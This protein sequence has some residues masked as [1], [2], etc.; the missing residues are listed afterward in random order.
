MSG[1][2]CVV[3][4]GAIGGLFAAH[5]AQLPELEVWVYDT[6]AE[7]VAAINSSGVRV[8]GARTLTG[9]VLARSDPREIPTCHFGIVA[10]KGT[11]T[12]AAITA[13]AAVLSGAAVVSVQNGVGNEE[14]I[15]R[16]V[17]RVIRGVTLPAVAPDGPGAV[18]L[19]GGGQTWIGPFEP[20]PATAGEIERLAAWLTQS[21]LETLAMADARGAQWTK[22]LFNAATNPVCALTGLTHGQMC[23]H[24][25]SREL[26]GRLL[27]EGLAVTRALQ[28]KLIEDPVEMVDRL[29]RAN[30]MH[31]PSM[32]QDVQLR[33]ATEIDTLN[34]GIVAAGLDVGQPTPLNAAITS[35]V[36]GVEHSW[37]LDA[38]S[39]A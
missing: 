27:D 12:E 37:V 14:V 5:L 18:H 2:V 33:R 1:R 39:G 32:L 11:V 26:S 36:R 6:S 8:R 28:L 30:Y 22:L 29:G 19:I 10:T 21:G 20:Q 24:A 31:R 15:A 25:P 38:P 16:H 23:D 17:P 3:G 7:T 13:A 35:L 9:R 4:C 34:G